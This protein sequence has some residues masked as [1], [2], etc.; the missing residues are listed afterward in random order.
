VTDLAVPVVLQ[1]RVGSRRLP[2]KVLAD[3]G[4]RPLI[5]WCIRRL[6]A[7]KVGPVILATTVRP[8]DDALEA[9]ATR[10]GIRTVRGPEDDVLQRFVLAA[11][12]LDARFLIRATADNPA[13][14]MEAPRRVVEAMTAGGADHVVEEG[15]PLGAAVEGVRTAALYQASVQTRDPYDREHVTPFL[16]RTP[17]R[18]LALKPLAPADLRRPDL[19][20]T[21]DTREDL[22][23]MRAVFDHVE[24]AGMAR[25]ADIIRA[26]EAVRESA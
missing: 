3:I 10:L 13:V 2:G 19:R 26:A 23:F 1:A 12:Y 25:L 21:V 11:D 15:L 9:V 5:E 22:A 17:G 18:F 24:G 7:A 16:Y 14:D 6:A 8:A 4:G 20:L